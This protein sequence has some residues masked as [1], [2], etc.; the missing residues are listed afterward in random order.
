MNYSGTSTLSS[1]RAIQ[2][3][4]GTPVS[5]S[6]NGS[7]V[8]SGALDPNGHVAIM[9]T[10]SVPRG[11]TV[12]VNAGST[13]TTTTLSASTPGTVA[14]VVVNADGTLSVTTAPDLDGSGTLSA[15]NAS[16]P[17]AMTETEDHEGD[18]SQIDAGDVSTLPSN[19]PV[20]IVATCS[21]ITLTPLTSISRLIFFEKGSD[22]GSDSAAQFTYDGALAGPMTFPIVA[23]A[24]RVHIQIFGAQGNL[25]V[26]VVAPILVV[27]G[28][29][30]PPSACP[31]PIASPSASPTATPSALPTATPTA[32]PTA[33]PSASPTVTPSALPTALPT[34]TPT[35]RAL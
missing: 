31:S 35:A 12:Q 33:I 21:S 24:T 1:G 2:S 4:A 8:G 19:L 22:N 17:D 25:L 14:L 20:S 29:S 16:S 9:F 30:T 10:S 26:N 15:T 34:A 7:V 28:S 13:T 6:L 27:T 5:V 23:G 3:L 32:S 11:V 18:I